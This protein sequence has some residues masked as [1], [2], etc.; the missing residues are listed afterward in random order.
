MPALLDIIS[1]NRQKLEDI[2]YHIRKVE[3]DLADLRREKEE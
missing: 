2:Q 1:T 3:Y